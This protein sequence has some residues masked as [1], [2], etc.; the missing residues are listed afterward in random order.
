[1]N[2]KKWTNHKGKKIK[3]RKI[4]ND[5]GGRTMAVLTSCKPS[6]FVIN[7]SKAKAFIEESNRNKITDS[8]LEECR[9]A[10]NLFR[11]EKRD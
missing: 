5:N 1:M 11:K 10:A 3:L 8:F 4:L 2:I 6:K 9:Q 7:A